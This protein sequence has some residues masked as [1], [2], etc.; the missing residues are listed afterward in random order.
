LRNLEGEYGTPLALSAV[1]HDAIQGGALV[2]LRTFLER[3][4]SLYKKRWVPSVGEVVG[5][6]LRQL[7]VMGNGEDKLVKGN[8]VVVGNVEVGHAAVLNSR[9]ERVGNEANG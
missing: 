6:G 4:E 7:G 5:W 8:F 2:D 1:L 3:K 9:Y